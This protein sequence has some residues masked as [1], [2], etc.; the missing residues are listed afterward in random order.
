MLGQNFIFIYILYA[1]IFCVISLSIGTIFYS[2]FF[3]WHNNNVAYETMQLK[4]GLE[5]T[6][7]A[8][9]FAKTHDIPKEIIP[10]FQHLMK[11]R[12]LMSYHG[13]K[14]VRDIVIGK[15]WIYLDRNTIHGMWAI[16]KRDNS[17]KIWCDQLFMAG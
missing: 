4:L 17:L 1:C 5:P 16:S 8:S 12:F 15:K 7:Q 3:L 2:L 14:S 6:Y 11:L 10:L 13:K 9:N